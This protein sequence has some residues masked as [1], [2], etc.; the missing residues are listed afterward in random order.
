[1]FFI[2][3]AFCAFLASCS[4][5]Q[6]LNLFSNFFTILSFF[7]NQANVFSLNTCDFA[8][9]RHLFCCSTPQGSPRVFEYPLTCYFRHCINYGRM[10]LIESESCFDLGCAVPLILSFTLTPGSLSSVTSN[11]C[12]YYTLSQDILDSRLDDF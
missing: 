11:P 4:V 1:M 8:S 9:R 5:Q 2:S 3:A 10:E 12:C 7:L 6:R